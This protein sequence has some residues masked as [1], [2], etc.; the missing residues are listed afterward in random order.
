MELPLLYHQG[1]TGKMYQWKIWTKGSTIYQEYGT[2]DGEKSETKKTV[3]GKNIGKANETTPSQQAESEAKA[4]WQKKK[5]TKYSET[6]SKAEETVFLPMLAHDYKKSKKGLEYPVDTQPKLNG[7]RCMAFWMG[8]HVVLMS[9]GGKEY[10]VPHIVDD[11]QKVLPKDYVADGELYVHGIPLQDIVHLVKN[12]G[13]EEQRQVE[14]WVFDGFTVG[15]TEAT[16]P[17]RE[18]TLMNWFGSFDPDSIT[19]IQPVEVAEVASEEELKSMLQ[20]YEE[21]GYEGAIIRLYDF[22]Y[23]LGHRSRGLWKLKN[24]FDQEFE[25]VGFTEA[26]GNDKGTVV[27]ECKTPKGGTFTVRPKGTREMRAKWYAH[28]KDYI[29]RKLTVKYQELTKDGIPEFPVGIVIRDEADL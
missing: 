8:D 15:C 11:L 4:L 3:K 22:P 28:G 20:Y 13:T 19:S 9:R 25:I 1:R 26:T 10:S 16:W 23:E 2:V 7:V 14:F 27:W 17:M 18:Q 6:Q 5:D 21:M 24:F 12:P 29:G